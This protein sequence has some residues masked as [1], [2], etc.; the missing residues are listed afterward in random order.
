MLDQYRKVFYGLYGSTG[1]DLRDYLVGEYVTSDAASRGTAYHEMI[2]NSPDPYLDLSTDFY[3]VY[4]KDLKKDWLFHPQAVEPIYEYLKKYPGL[5]FE[6]WVSHK[7]QIDGHEVLMR[8]KIDGLNG[9]NIHETKT[10]KRKP[11]STDYFDTLQWRCYLLALPESPSVTYNVFQLGARNNWARTTEFTFERD[12]YNETTV[13]RYLSGFIAWCFAQDD[14]R[15]L[16]RITL[17][18]D[19]NQFSEI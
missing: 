17:K 19:K 3:K 15:I 12:P 9:L 8:M 4:E 1:D 18:V 10:T 5:I 6:T 2:E 16:D 7:L 13:R 11:K 14:E